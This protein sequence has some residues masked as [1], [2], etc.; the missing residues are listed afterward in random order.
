VPHPKATGFAGCLRVG[1]P[2]LSEESH[3]KRW[4]TR[5]V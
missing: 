4:G 3:R 5:P 2:S 1:F